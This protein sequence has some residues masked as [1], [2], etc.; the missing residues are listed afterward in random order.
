MSEELRLEGVKGESE[1]IC[2]EIVG[3]EMEGFYDEGH[4]RV[5]KR[6]LGEV[7]KN[8]LNNVQVENRKEGKANNCG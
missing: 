7:D 3:E 1:C 5:D 8:V 6:V 2:H 4:R